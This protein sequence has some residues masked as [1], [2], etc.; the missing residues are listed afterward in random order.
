MKKLTALTIIVLFL[1]GSSLYGCAGGS[2]SSSD[3]GN[4]SPY[5]NKTDKKNTERDRKEM[6]EDILSD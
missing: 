1:L 2:G 4:G 6:R 3:S 5:L